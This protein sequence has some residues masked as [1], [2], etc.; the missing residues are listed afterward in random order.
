MTSERVKNA[1]VRLEILGKVGRDS[2]D[3]IP[4]PTSDSRDARD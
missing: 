1:L 3:A 2:S 4:P